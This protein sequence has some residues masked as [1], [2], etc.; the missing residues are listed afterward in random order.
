VGGKPNTAPFCHD[1]SY[2]E[3]NAYFRSVL[4]EVLQLRLGNKEK[5][6]HERVALKKRARQ[7]KERIFFEPE[8]MQIV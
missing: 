1:G 6:R 2:L 7:K 4:A 5:E 3:D 8:C